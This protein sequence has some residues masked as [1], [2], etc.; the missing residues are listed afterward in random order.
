MESNKQERS[1]LIND[2]PVTSRASGGSWMSKHMLKGS[3]LKAEG[4]RE[5]HKMSNSEYEAHLSSPGGMK[6][7]GSPTN[8]NS[9]FNEGTA[10]KIGKAV[11][12]GVS[13][14]VKA[15]KKY[16][17]VSVTKRALESKTGRKLSTAAK[18]ILGNNVTRVN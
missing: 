4:G 3:P 1:N 8:M 12:K 13:K 10:E 17:I 11:D 6:Q 2:N 7:H 9:P 18:N 5:N 15:A 14:V 16:N